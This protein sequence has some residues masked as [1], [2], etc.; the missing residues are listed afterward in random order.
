MSRGIH[1]DLRGQACFR[2]SIFQDGLVV[3][4]LLVIVLSDGDKEL[5]LGL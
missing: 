5:R 1:L 3:R 4:R 2:K